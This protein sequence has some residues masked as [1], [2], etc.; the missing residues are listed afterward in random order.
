VLHKIS[1]DVKPRERV[2]F[3]SWVRFIYMKL[4]VG[5]SV[6]SAAL[7]LGNHRSRCPCSG[8]RISPMAPS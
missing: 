8:L 1:F 6:L 2:S 5:R 3:R 4:T 7:G